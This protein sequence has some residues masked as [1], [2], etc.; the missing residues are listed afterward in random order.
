[1]KKLFYLAIG[2]ILCFTMCNDKEEDCSN[3][4][5]GANCNTEMRSKF[6]GT[7]VGIL[8]G[9]GMSENVQTTMSE[10]PGDVMK[11]KWDDQSYLIVTGSTTFDIPYQSIEIAGE[12]MSIVG[13][14]SLNG[15]TLTAT[16][17]NGGARQSL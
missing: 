8:S 13:G 2:L 3:G 16:F 11:I 1:M 12:V 5:E 6:Y 15:S 9:G 7:Y 4:Y 10:F 17:D 14:G